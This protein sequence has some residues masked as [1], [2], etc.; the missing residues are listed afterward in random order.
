MKQWDF[1]LRGESN[2]GECYNTSPRSLIIGSENCS[3]TRVIRKEANKQAEVFSLVIKNTMEEQWF[4]KSSQGLSSITIDEEELIKLLR[5]E[6]LNK[7]EKV[8][9]TGQFLFTF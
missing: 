3:G 2:G 9:E 8:Q 5:G 1:I 6:S 4:R 7:Q